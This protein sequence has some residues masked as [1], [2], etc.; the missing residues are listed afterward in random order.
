LIESFYTV[1]YINAVGFFDRL[2]GVLRSYLNDDDD[3]Q[4]S[5]GARFSTDRDFAEAFEELN[6]FLSGRSSS[7]GGGSTADW[8]SGHA[9]PNRKPAIPETL[10]PDFEELGVEFGADA[11]K[12]KSAYKQML[13]IHHPD[14]HASHEGNMKKATA[15]S[16]KINAAY[17]RICEWRKT[18]KV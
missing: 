5:R 17:K 9:A 16:V 12:C 6:E 8:S 11:E 14:R 3:W 13:N 1:W 4:D 2:G 18:G 7:G 15:K 10:K